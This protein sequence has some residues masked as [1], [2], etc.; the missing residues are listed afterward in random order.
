VYW[1][2]LEVE[3]LLLFRR[4]RKKLKPN[5]EDAVKGWGN[6]I[7]L[8]INDAYRLSWDDKYLK[9]CEEQE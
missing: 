6:R 9:L 5:P 3:H 7:E 8:N 1:L 4:K 2:F